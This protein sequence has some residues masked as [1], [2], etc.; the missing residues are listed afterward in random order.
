MGK[1]L[2]TFKKSCVFLLVMV[3]VVSSAIPAFA[4][5]FS[6]ESLSENLEY[7]NFDDKLG[8]A[9]VLML[10]SPIVYENVYE[11]YYVDYDYDHL[12]PILKDNTV[13]IPIGFIEY[14]LWTDVYRYEDNATIVIELEDKEIKL[15]LESNEMIVNG[16][17]LKMGAP[18]QL[19]E[20]R[21]FI[22][23]RAIAE[24]L[25]KEVFYD[26]GLIIISDIEDILDVSSEKWYIDA[27][28]SLFTKEPPKGYSHDYYYT[29]AELFANSY[30]N[31]Q[32]LKYIDKFTEEIPDFTE[33]YTKF[34]DAFLLET[35]LLIRTEEYDELV[36]YCN[37]A[38]AID[39]SNFLLYYIKGEALELGERYTEAIVALNE[40]INLNPKWMYSYE[41]KKRAFSDLNQYENYLNVYYD[42]AKL[43]ISNAEWA[44]TV[45]M[46]L[47]NLGEW[48]S[49]IKLFDKVMAENKGNV[50]F[51]EYKGMILYYAGKLKDAIDIFDKVLERDEDNFYANYY[52]YL[53]LWQLEEY[54]QGI[55]IFEKLLDIM[56]LYAKEYYDKGKMLYLEG[57]YEAALIAYSFSTY[58]NNKY[59]PAYEQ[60]ANILFKMGDV[61][62]ALEEMSIAISLEPEN[63]SYY[64]NIAWFLL[65][66]GI[67]E[68]A[69]EYVNQGIKL[70]GSRIEP[71]ILDT[72]G[73]ILYNLG[74][75]D[76]AIIDFT[77]VTKGKDDVSA[78]NSLYGIA[79]ISAIKNENEKALEYLEK[80]FQKDKLYAKRAKWDRVFKGMKNTSEF[81]ML[82]DQYDK[83][84]TT[85]NWN[86]GFLN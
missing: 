52:K 39:P 44:Y 6:V 41:V 42:L 46:Q 30:A 16:T 23:L 64:N 31:V 86:L 21:E 26:R 80:A 22:P 40:A 82:I 45:A 36:D 43:D 11:E 15:V 49:G 35:K 70:S 4:H 5:D 69:L 25:D 34:Y 29:M 20:N 13:L 17:P 67:Y 10:D 38:I 56:P 54:K 72:R 18:M 65:E 75:Y 81:K 60:K 77:A 85:S 3:I 37:K 53:S 19:I 68:E 63:P 47:G 74:K 24:A 2:K 32:A 61:E 9:F 84:T 79:C 55:R 48:E 8:D 58:L 50:K 83:V 27:L 73:W 57:N 28:I 76:R 12:G 1:V 62:G 33:Y 78:A 66:I 71:A 14:I 59:A 7:M 51:D